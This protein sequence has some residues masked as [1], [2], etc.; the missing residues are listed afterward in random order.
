MYNP[1]VIDFSYFNFYGVSPLKKDTNEFMMQSV[2]KA[3]KIA[4]KMIRSD[5][6]LTDETDKTDEYNS[7]IVFTGDRG[8]GKSTAMRTFIDD[9]SITSFET[10][11]NKSFNP[12]V[13]NL[14]VIDPTM[15]M[16]GEKLVGAIVSHIYNAVK[17]AV[18]DKNTKFEPDKVRKVYESCD[19]AH[20]ALRVFY[21]GVKDTVKDDIDSLETLDKLTSST[22]L[23]K[24]LNNLFD[25][26][27]EWG[28]HDTLLIPIDDVDMKVA[29]IYELLEEVRN[30]LFNKRVLVVMA[31]KLE[32]LADSI[33]QHF[34]KYMGVLPSATN[35]LDAQPEEMASKYLL[36][37]IPAPRRVDLPVLRP[38]NMSRYKVKLR[39]QDGEEP[40]EEPLVAKFM[41]LVYQATGIVMVK[42]SANSHA[43]IPTNMRALHHVFNMLNL[44]CKPLFNENGYVADFSKEPN[45][46]IV[47][48]AE[49]W[50]ISEKNLPQYVHCYKCANCKG[51]NL[52][53]RENQHYY[54]RCDECAKHLE[55][56]LYTLEKWV[57]DSA[58][59]NSVPRELARIANLFAEHSTNGIHAF[60]IKELDSYS[61]KTDVQSIE[62]G[63]VVKKGLFCEN[64]AI[65]AMLAPEALPENISIGDALYALHLL[66]RLNQDTG[67][68]RF[69]AV[70]KMLYSI[71]MT[72]ATYLHWYNENL[73]GENGEKDAQ[74]Y[75]ALLEILN[76]LV[77][78]PNM[79]LTYEDS[80]YEPNRE[81]NCVDIAEE[82]A[83]NNSLANSVA[84]RLLFF[85]G[86]GRI[87]GRDIHT[88]RRT[89][90]VDRQ[91]V[92][93]MRTR[94]RA[95]NKGEPIFVQF[96][97]MAMI[98]NFLTP[99]SDFTKRI[100]D[101]FP[102]EMSEGESKI[103]EYLVAVAPWKKSSMFL[104]LSLSCVDVIDAFIF[105]MNRE[106]DFRYVTYEKGE[107]IDGQCH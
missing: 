83:G 107:C 97:Y 22:L 39:P 62:S 100:K 44:H 6:E 60:L 53:E 81:V 61:A 46:C 30:Y 28:N 33:E 59:S 89:R 1:Y 76:G 52:Y 40:L 56:N 27:A 91:T 65:K 45:S 9:V 54:V 51:E 72:R 67:I 35:P 18:N 42:N 23:R 64:S 8:S 87:K 99:K 79:R 105:T 14:S 7:L 38:E 32:Q 15:F 73:F 5:K 66:E 101:M 34:R 20:A 31:V 104:L 29:D 2:E 25:N 78:N 86:A 21:T 41:K 48:S 17:E 85:V 92:Q 102:K 95:L 77:Y 75:S 11:N 71:R 13:R 4:E 43:L 16:G 10:D 3:K 88:I 36:K 58:C 106:A 84:W 82:L 74:K 69:V 98:N 103:E 50:P 49:K 93:Y 26:F 94:L 90:V 70:I 57:I 96:N 68:S 80:G 24:K 37:L 19:E 55:H 63:K 47:E 12:R